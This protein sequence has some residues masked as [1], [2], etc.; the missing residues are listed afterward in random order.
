MTYV[1][2]DGAMGT[3]VQKRSLDETATEGSASGI[4]AET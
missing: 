2:L 3:M 1:I 4:L